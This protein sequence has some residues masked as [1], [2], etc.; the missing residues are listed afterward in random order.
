MC[1]MCV[2][3]DVLKGI[4]PSNE[5]LLRERAARV[6]RLVNEAETRKAETCDIGEAIVDLLKDEQYRL[7]RQL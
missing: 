5:Q 7:A 6:K 2:K 4:N 3:D 1:Y